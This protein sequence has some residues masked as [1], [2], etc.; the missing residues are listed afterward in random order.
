MFSHYSRAA[1]GQICTG[2]RRSI[3]MRQPMRLS[4]LSRPTGMVHPAAMAR[5]YMMAGAPIRQF[6]T[7]DKKP[8]QEE[9]AKQE[10]QEEEKKEEEAPPKFEKKKPNYTAHVLF[11]IALMSAAIWSTF[12]QGGE[13]VDKETFDINDLRN[14]HK[15]VEMTLAPVE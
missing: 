6:S 10:Q 14:K 5:P 13:V 11:G 12:S 2:A 15:V 9:P 8:E 1:A 3:S 7:P 4:M